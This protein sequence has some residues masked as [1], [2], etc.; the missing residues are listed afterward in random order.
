[1]QR[2]S[3]VRGMRVDPPSHKV[4]S[5]GENSNAFTVPRAD[6]F[7][8]RVFSFIRLLVLLAPLNGALCVEEAS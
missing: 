2:R 4:A 3:K 5:Q 6:R 7:P 1:M 8:K